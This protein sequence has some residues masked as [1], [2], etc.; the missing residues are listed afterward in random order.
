[1]LCPAAETSAVPCHLDTP[2]SF[3]LRRPCI[4]Y[5]VHGRGEANKRL[6]DSKRGVTGSSYPAH[7][8]LVV[9]QSLVS[10]LGS[11]KIP[12]PGL[13]KKSRLSSLVIVNIP[14]VNKGVVTIYLSPQNDLASDM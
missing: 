1:M 12:F 14:I 6:T 3:V 2:V 5:V 9:G 10:I 11:Q 13:I 7:N 8:R 4:W